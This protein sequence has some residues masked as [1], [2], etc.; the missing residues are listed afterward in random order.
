M[1][2]RQCLW[3]SVQMVRRRAWVYAA[4]LLPVVAQVAWC[5]TFAPH[6]AVGTVAITKPNRN[7]VRNE[8]WLAGTVHT[9]QCSTVTDWDCNVDT[10][11]R[12]LDSVTHWWEASRGTFKDND[13]I[14]VLVNYICPATAG[15]A[16][17][18]AKADDN[19]SDTNSALAEEDG[20]SNTETIDVIVPV[21]DELSYGGDHDITDVTTPQYVR[22]PAY[23]GPTAYTRGT[24]TGATC[25]V[26]LWAANSA[27]EASTVYTYGSISTADLGEWNQTANSTIGTAWPTAAIA[28]A[29]SVIN[30][31]TV[32]KLSY[33]TKWKYYDSTLI[34]PD[35][36][37]VET[38]TVA[39]VMYLTFDTPERVEEKDAFETSTNYCTGLGDANDNE[40]VCDEVLSGYAGEYVYDGTC[41]WD[42]SNFVRLIGVQGV[43]GTLHRW[44]LDSTPVNGDLITMKTR[45]ISLINADQTDWPD[46]RTE[47]TNYHQ[48]ATAESFNW[49]ASS[50]TKR[51]T[52]WGDY[53][54]W[55]FNNGGVDDY[56]VKGAPDF[57]KAN[58]AGQA[59]AAHQG[60]SHNTPVPTLYG[61]RKPNEMP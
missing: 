60:A 39:R 51:A 61:F 59:A 6:T 32:K 15:T 25:A 46:G 55:V 27:D 31:E 34:F 24:A 22:S 54:D 3:A 9:A 11:Q 56:E 26:K 2:A 35:K 28:H 19:Y 41:A 45:W 23:N 14:G 58:P 36:V 50:D 40:D 4:L 42:S 48:W 57:W 44:A 49:D 30:A 20:T 16:V 5:D 47:W 8:R 38:P 10:Q 37:Y 52:T 17:L 12:V 43:A 21:I 1:K 33:T 7:P 53:E 13:N 18:T 29:L